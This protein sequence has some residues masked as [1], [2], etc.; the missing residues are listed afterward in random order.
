MFITDK[1][2]N[3]LLNSDSITCI[4]REEDFCFPENGL[5]FTSSDSYKLLINLVGFVACYCSLHSSCTLAVF[6]AEFPR[7]WGQ[8]GWKQ[9]I[10]TT[11]CKLEYQPI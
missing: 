3:M 1:Q 7:V 8:G 4:S 5:G 6:L 2:S 9:C 10:S 11:E